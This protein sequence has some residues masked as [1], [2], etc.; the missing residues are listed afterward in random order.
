MYVPPLLRDIF[1]RRIPQEMKHR[2]YPCELSR[3]TE[4]FQ[5]C[6]W[7]IN[8]QS[9]ALWSKEETMICTK[10]AT[11]EDPKEEGEEPKKKKNTPKQ[12]TKKNPKQEVEEKKEESKQ[13]EEEEEEPKARRRKGRIQSMK[14]K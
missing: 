2:S 3:E 7:L 5:P 11:E 9:G 14:N 10:T 8:S 1:E 6:D 12:E 13:E 4:S